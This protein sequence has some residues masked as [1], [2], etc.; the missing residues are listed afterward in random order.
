MIAS[1]TVVDSWAWVELFKGSAYGKTAKERIEESE[2]T[3]TPSLV[4]AE[5]ARKY[6]REG[7]GHAKIRKWLQSISEATQVI[8]I[9]VSLA[10]ES[11]KA[12]IELVNKA[13]DEGIRKPGLADGVV[14]ATARVCRAN[15]LTGDPHF[16]GLPETFWLGE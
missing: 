13:R 9:D 16:K 12:S 10:E 5:L 6:L 11:A 4:L 14:L 3:F 8:E 2:D 15:L 7:E 1:K